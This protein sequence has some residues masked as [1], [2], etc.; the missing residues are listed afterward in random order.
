MRSNESGVYYPPTHQPRH[1]I[2]RLK[3]VVRTTTTL[4]ARGTNGSY[5]VAKVPPRFHVLRPSA[6][7]AWPALSPEERIDLQRFCWYVTLYGLCFVQI[8]ISPLAKEYAFAY[9][10]GCVFLLCYPTA[11]TW[12]VK[13]CGVLIRFPGQ[14]LRWL[15]RCLGFGRSGVRS[16][17]SHAS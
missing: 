11:F 16:S 6:Y 4:Q 9:I 10:S 14:I 5:L 17:T 7:L 1:V 13:L 12:P 3:A 8:L 2:R 15:V